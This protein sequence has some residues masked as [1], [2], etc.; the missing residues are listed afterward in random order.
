MRGNSARGPLDHSSRGGGADVAGVGRSL[1][2]DQQNVRFA[3]RHGP[4]LD[5]FGNHEDLAG[6][7]RYG[8]VAHLNRDAAAQDEEEVVRIV[9]FVPH[10]FTLDFRDHDVVAVELADDA[11]LPMLGKLRQFRLYSRD[12]DQFWTDDPRFARFLLVFYRNKEH[13]ITDFTAGP[14]Q[15]VNAAYRGASTFSYPARYDALVG[16]YEQ[17]VDGD[18]SVTRVI[19]VRGQLTFDGT[20]PLVDQGN[21]TFRVGHSVVRFD[22]EFAGKRQ[23]MWLDDIESDRIDLP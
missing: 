12:D 6:T 11:R 16:R 13:V 8:S 5:A 15:F 4:V 1:R 21:D 14:E 2:F 19:E 22:H 10:E 18:L 23:R 3:F 20:T 7:K 9:V 17:M